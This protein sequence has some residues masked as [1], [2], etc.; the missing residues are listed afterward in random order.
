MP[1]SF[2]SGFVSC[3]TVVCKCELIQARLT[4]IRDRVLVT[5]MC[6]TAASVCFLRPPDANTVRVSSSE[7]LRVCFACSRST[8]ADLHQ[9][10]FQAGV[11][12]K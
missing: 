9:L 8:P 5:L 6:A 1:V 4:E 7:I 12:N 11:H 3:T 2:A 10:V